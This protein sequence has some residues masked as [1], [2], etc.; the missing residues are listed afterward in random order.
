VEKPPGDNAYINGG[1]FVLNPGAIDHIEGDKTSWESTPL[2]VLA[3][4]QQLCAYRHYGFWQPMDTMRE[5][6]LLEEL[7]QSG[8]APW[9]QWA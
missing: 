6:M 1:F 7:W 5:K 2:E 8:R 9:R 4:G 3:R